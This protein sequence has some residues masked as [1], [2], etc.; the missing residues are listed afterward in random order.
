M[1]LIR[2][3]NIYRLPITR[4]I[5][6]QSKRKLN[7]GLILSQVENRNDV[8]NARV[9]TELQRTKLQVYVF[10]FQSEMKVQ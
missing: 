6:L 9:K 5:Q 4:D 8:S 7:F 3:A 10:V 2:W 1:I